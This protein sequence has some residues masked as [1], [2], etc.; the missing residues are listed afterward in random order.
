MRLARFA[1]GGADRFG[2]VDGDEA[3]ALDH[4]VATFE[5]LLADPASRL[6]GR[7]DP[8][9]PGADVRWLPPI[10]PTAKVVCVGLN[11]ATHTAEV[12]RAA[13]PHPTVFPR[14][15]DSFVGAGQPVVRPFDAAALD[16]EGEAGLVIGSFARRVAAEDA[17][18]HVAG[19]TCLAENSER[20]WQAHSG[21]VTAGKNWFA[22][23]SCGPW[24]T[25]TDELQLPLRVTTRLSG[26][27]VQY[28]TT[29]HLTFGF[30]ELVSYIS[31]FTPLRPGDVIATGTP[32]GVGARRDP[33]RFLQPGDELAVEVWGVGVLRNTVVAEA[34]PCRR[35][36]QPVSSSGGQP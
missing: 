6:A 35:P 22:S 10:V 2:I 1:A 11:F 23:G 29:D 36:P 34:P 32:A 9:W 30:A 8:R 12:A 17:L 13:A 20:E 18:A 3:V 24:V 5:Q 25:T 14:F 4:R 7:A 33:P 15:P 21:Q 16:W 27:V 19:F 28:D 26:H 31:T